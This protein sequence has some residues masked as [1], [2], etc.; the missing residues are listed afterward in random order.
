MQVKRRYI[1]IIYLC[2]YIYV[3][4]SI[5]SRLNLDKEIKEFIGI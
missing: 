2:V 3:Y 5:V 1:K 4:Q